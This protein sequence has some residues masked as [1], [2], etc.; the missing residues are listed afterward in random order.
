MSEEQITLT[1]F[2]PSYL[3]LVVSSRHVAKLAGSKLNTVMLGGEQCVAE[4]VAK[5]WEVVPAARVFNRYGPTEA[6]IAVTTYEVTRDDVATGRI[7]PAGPTR[8]SSFFSSPDNGALVEGSDEEGELYRHSWRTADA[9]GYWGDE[10]LSRQVLRKDIVPDQVLYKT[11]DT[12]VPRPARA[13]LLPRAPGPMSSS[14][15]GSGYH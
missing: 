12:G 15:T 4:D 3:R 14:A 8:A 5:L 7:P 10:E 13:L 1:S 11:G 6:T 9:R 2:S